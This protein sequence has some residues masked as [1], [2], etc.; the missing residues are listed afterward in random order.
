MALINAILHY[1]HIPVIIMFFTRTLES[2]YPWN[3][4]HRSTN[5]EMIQKQEFQRF[6]GIIL[7]Y[8][9]IGDFLNVMSDSC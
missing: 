5:L 1:I 8:R 4:D 2:L 3:P 6:F 7:F 9:A